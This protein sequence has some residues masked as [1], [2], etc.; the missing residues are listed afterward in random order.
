MKHTAPLLVALFATP[1]LATTVTIDAYTF[2]L[3]QF[4]GA[5][6]TYR[7]DASGGT[8][9]F[10]GKLWDNEAGVDGFTPGELAAGQFGSD[11]GDQIT[12]Q[13]RSS[14]DWFQL[15]YAGAG[16][17]IGGT[18]NDTFVVYEITSSNSGVDLEGTSW[19]ISF[20]GGTLINASSGTASFLTYQPTA[21]NVNQIAFDLTSFGFSSGDF[22]KSVYI[23]N[24]DSGSG[25][26]D[27]DFIFTA[28]EGITAT[29]GP[30]VI[31]TPAAFGAGLIGLSLI[32][33]R[34]TK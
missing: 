26:S 13:K 22:L 8:V 28:L 19:K 27:P 32:A 31:P 29:G 33:L 12:L 7:T 20:N 21:E 15:T 5:A 34:R 30:T 25:T 14:P 10:D 4:T 16:I 11:P 24:I 6:V 3:D 18:N 2:D 17:P 23:E 1:A 9:D